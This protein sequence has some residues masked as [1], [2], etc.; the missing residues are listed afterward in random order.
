MKTLVLYIPFIV[1]WS[2]L[3]IPE[4]AFGLAWSS[5]V[6]LILLVING[7]FKPRNYN[8]SWMQYPLRPLYVPH[9]IFAGYMSI[10]SIFYFWSLY[11]YVYLNKINPPASTEI[12][13]ITAW[14]QCLY[15]LGHASLIHGLLLGS[16]YQMPKIQLRVKSL[17]SFS[18]QL[19]IVF[20]IL[21]FGLYTFPW[22][23]QLKERVNQISSVATAI[24]LAVAIPER[25]PRNLSIALIFF[26][27]NMLQALT[28][29]WKESI[30]TPLILL[31][32]FLLPVYRTKILVVGA[33]LF[34]TLMAVLP[35][36][37]AVIRENSWQNRLAPTEALAKA[38]SAV[39]DQSTLS[40][41]N[42]EFLTGRFSEISLFT[43]YLDNVPKNRDFYYEDIILQGLESLIPR[44]LLPN[45]GVTEL[46]VME[47]VWENRVVARISSVSA[48][49]QLVVDGYLSFGPFGVWLFCFLT[50]W[51]AA[52]ISN[53]AE[54]LFG[55]YFLGTAIV[56]SSLFSVYWRGNCFEFML[57]II[58]WSTV[59]MFFLYFVFSMLR[60]VQLKHKF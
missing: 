21:A 29:G 15:Y 4:L 40:E 37:N 55:G 51:S 50:G 20:T 10:S 49:P 27:I 26:S 57:N 13:E 17:S 48:K 35:T 14:A 41:A 1:A 34:I 11:G 28:S 30:L 22:L 39:G 56:F 38:V 25:N 60:I 12:F 2:L 23:G 36:F 31:F 16:N 46:L 33:P 5:S 58:V 43:K 47:R 19:S 24:A 59:I 6:V 45:K 8:G 54:Q 32:T 3:G 18:L 7:V 9:F 52:R 44:I 53:L 42:W